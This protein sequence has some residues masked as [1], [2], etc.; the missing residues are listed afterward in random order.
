VD[1]QRAISLQAGESLGQTFV[2]RQ[3]ALAGIEIYLRPEAPG[4]GEVRL[5]LYSDSV[6]FSDLAVASLSL[7]A[8]SGPGFYRFSFPP[9]PD[10]AGHYYYAE[11]EL[12]AAGG[13]RVGSAPGDAYLDGAM[14]QLRNPLDAQMSFRLVYEPRLAALGLARNGLTWIGVLGVGVLLFVLPG[15]A[16][17]ILLWP[18]H[19]PLPW[20]AKL[21]LAGGLSLAIYP[22]LMLWTDLAGIHLGSLYA[23]LPIS[24]ALAILI[25]RGMK[26]PDNGSRKLR[27]RLPLSGEIHAE[28][29]W[30]DLAFL[31]V[32]G[33]IFLVRFWGIE[34]LAAPMWGDSYQHTMIAQLL[35]DHGGLFRS[36]EPYADLQTFTY[37]FG[38]HAAAAGFHWVTE[39]PLARSVLWTGQ[40]LNGLAALSLYPLALKLGGNR[41]AGVGAVLVA[42]LLAPMPMF[43]TNWGRYTQ[44]AGQ[45]I[46]PGAV[47]LAWIALETSDF[48]RPTAD[49][50][51]QTADSRRQTTDGRRQAADSRRRLLVLAGIAIGGLALTHYRVLIFAVLFLAAF[52]LLKALRG[53]ARA[54]FIGTLW[55]GIGAGLLF[56]P[57]FIRTFAGK[58]TLIF[59]SQLSAPAG[60]ASAW[61]QQYNAIGNLFVYLP[62]ALWLLLPI[63]I[64]WGLWRRQEGVALISLWSL[65]LL[66]S[67]NPQWFGLPGQ[68]AIS[69]FALFIAAYVPAGILLG[70]GD[71]WLIAES[72]S[73]IANAES[74]IPKPEKRIANPISKIQNAESKIPR[75]GF[76]L[77]LAVLLLV[78]G[79][80][81]WGARGR[82]GDLHAA[83]HALVTRPD[84]RAA[85]WIRENIPG[86]ARFLV[87]SFLAYDDA[88][89]VGSDGGWWLPLLAR[90]ETTLPP[91]N[92]GSEQ[93]PRPGYR[94][95]INL[96]S[97]EVL[98]KGIDHPDVLALLRARGITHIYLG[99]R[100]GQVNYGGPVL[101]PERLLASPHFRPVYHQDRA[102][103]FEILES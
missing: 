39:L 91:I 85:A 44:L 64:A 93:G 74:R 37:H 7:K 8:V 48:G 77:P 86:E 28:A 52:L 18:D 51:Q 56:L 14:Y 81:L 26:I 65:L 31:V 62:P 83:E 27:F 21:G 87:N 30:P 38:F 47:Y 10:S 17:L 45:V 33:L 94:E 23:W 58:I 97:A 96:M 36:W 90:R 70:A 95:W 2:A 41:W 5:H 99:Q 101:E 98:S 4:D 32:A 50:G 12:E 9:R 19:L 78:V 80:G 76:G 55:L 49:G 67:A 61:L 22:I 6:S 92:Y 1:E 53:Q 42:G 100:K 43:Y 54:P 15:W 29:F 34:A 84:V 102:W 71:G 63:T 82:L 11:L 59:A 13:L 72:R 57:W 3:A 20:P 46:L 60:E 35:V 88:L 103:V 68:G 25:W 40:I 24:A 73:R 66:L 69:N 75:A 79:A 89:I 16:L